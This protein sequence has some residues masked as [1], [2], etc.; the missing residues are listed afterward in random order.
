MNTIYDIKIEMA[1]FYQSNVF[2]YFQD[3][4]DNF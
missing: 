4:G 2:E 1:F 3:F